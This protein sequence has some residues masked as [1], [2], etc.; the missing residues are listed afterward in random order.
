MKGD[1]KM[2]EEQRSL[3]SIICRRIDSVMERINK[4]DS[5]RRE[6]LDLYFS[7]KEEERNNAVLDKDERD[8][9]NVEDNLLN[10]FDKLEETII[11][12]NSFLKRL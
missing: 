7:V 2:S 12:T 6:K 10:F 11:D 3:S 4:L 9:K 1:E 5:F 8:A